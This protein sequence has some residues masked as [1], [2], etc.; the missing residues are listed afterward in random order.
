MGIEQF[1]K[2]DWVPLPRPGWRNVEVRVLVAKEQLSV[3]Q[4]RFGTDATIDEHSH[5]A[6][7]QVFCLEGT[8]FVSVGAE[9][10]EFR[11]GQRITWPAGVDHCLWTD[12]E[13]MVT[14][15][16]HVSD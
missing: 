9:V 12:S 11:S 5:H 7:A 16:V 13:S 2:P 14:L 4:L 15:M 3:A 6:D 8:G 10:S 1:E